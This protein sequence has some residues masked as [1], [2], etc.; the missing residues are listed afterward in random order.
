ME[1][2]LDSKLQNKVSGIPKEII[3]DS[4]IT[5]TLAYMLPNI[6]NVLTM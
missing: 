3:A 2:V 4:V 6:L 5:T 1:P